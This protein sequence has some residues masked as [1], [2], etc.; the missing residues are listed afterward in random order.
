M[1]DSLRRTLSKKDGDKIKENKDVEHSPPA[2]DDTPLDPRDL[3]AHVEAAAVSTAYERKVFVLN[4]V[5]NEYIGMGRF[6]WQ[7]FILSGFGWLV[8][9]I[10]LQGVAIILPQ[11]KRELTGY[12]PQWATFSLYIGLIIGA[13]LWGIMADIVGRRLSFN[14]TLFLAGTFGIAAGAAP[15]FVGLCGLLA[16]LGVGL[17]GNLPVDGMLFLEFIPG[18]NQ[19]LLTLLSVFW[20]IGQLIASLVAWAFIANYSC[21]DAPAG[22]EPPPPCLRAD[23]PGW[24]YTFYTLG[25][26]TFVLFIFRFAIFAL[27]ESPKFLVAKGRDAEAVAVMREIARRNGKELTH[28][29]LSVSLLR[30]LSGETVEDTDAVNKEEEE[31]HAPGAGGLVGA[32]KSVV[33]A[34][35]NI[36][37]GV[38]QIRLAHFK[39]DMSHVYP[40]FAGR[41]MAWNTSVVILLWGIIGL[42]YPLFNAFLPLLLSSQ[43]SSTYTTYRNYAIISVCGIPGSVLAAWMVDLPRSGRR[44]AM[45]I[46]TLATGLLLFGL[47]Q[48][49]NNE[50]GSLAINCV[51]ASAQNIMYGVLYSYTPECFPAPHRG[52]GDGIASSFNRVTGAMAPIIAIYGAATTIFP[53]YV[54][55]SLFIV[56]SLFM[57]TLQVESQGR[58]AL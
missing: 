7:L 3:A 43:S 17:G 6:Q 25:T 18:K 37:R 33:L 8:D 50:N 23:N 19:H 34:P 30:N 52:T 42:A 36:A 16:A 58:T 41:K 49:G 27:P 44:G 38:A 51:T 31:A 2:Y 32:L 29:Q 20:A 13:A 14:I 11:I 15:N 45:A 24:R 55:A 56:A 28:A 54:A 5:M 47:T 35:V 40:L 22:V 21:P 1:A 53:V 48:V 57:C 26:F 9:N 4:K 39:P 10:F 12:P 46:G